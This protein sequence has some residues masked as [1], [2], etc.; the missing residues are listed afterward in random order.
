MIVQEYQEV[1]QNQQIDF[2]LSPNT[3]G[4]KPPKISEITSQE[5]SNLDRS[6][7]FEFKMDYFT[8]LANCLGYVGVPALTMPLFESEGAKTEYGGFPGSI[9]L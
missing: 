3:F 8:A 2:I 7:V 1:M 6:P 5:Q 4:E 9:R